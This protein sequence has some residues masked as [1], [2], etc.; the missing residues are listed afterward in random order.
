MVALTCQLFCFILIFNLLMV[1][2]L[3]EYLVSLVPLLASHKT[4]HCLHNTAS[5]NNL[6]VGINIITLN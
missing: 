6:H 5:V 3:V 1:I 4:K 2:F